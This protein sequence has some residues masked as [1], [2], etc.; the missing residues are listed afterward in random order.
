ML[1]WVGPSLSASRCKSTGSWRSVD[2]IDIECQDASGEA[3]YCNMLFQEYTWTIGVASKC[4]IFYV[5]RWQ[6]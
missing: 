3:L 4:I 5:F 1:G 2:A 6:T